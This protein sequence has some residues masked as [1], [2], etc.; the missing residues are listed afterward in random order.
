MDKV[1]HIVAIVIWYGPFVPYAQMKLNYD[2]DFD[3]EGQGYIFV[4]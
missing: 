4:D 1:L 3:L 2:L